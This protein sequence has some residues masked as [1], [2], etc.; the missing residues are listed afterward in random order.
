MSIL[1]HWDET[2]SQM[3]LRKIVLVLSCPVPLFSPL[4]VCV[5]MIMYTF[6][7]SVFMLNNLFHLSWTL[8]C[9]YLDMLITECYQ[10][11]SL[12]SSMFFNYG[13]SM[14]S[15]FY[16][17]SCTFYCIDLCTRGNLKRWHVL[18]DM[19]WNYFF[20][21]YYF[22]HDFIH[23]H[24]FWQEENN[25][26]TDAASTNLMVRNRKEGRSKRTNK[27]KR[28]TERKRKEGGGEGGRKGKKNK[29]LFP[30]LYH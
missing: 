26:W 7:S 21:H 9:V 4:C 2:L 29:Q 14:T 30:V 12:P 23:C 22:W 16:F 13:I 15:A 6:C 3:Y 10:S 18:L 27:E 17:C 25:F 19:H 24:E 1:P 5:C 11:F 20:T 28:E 8:C